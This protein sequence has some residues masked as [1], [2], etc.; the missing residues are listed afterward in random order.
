VFLLF[1]YKQLKFLGTFDC[2]KSWNRVRK[3][4]EM[5]VSVGVLRMKMTWS[6]DC[7]ME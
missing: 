4:V 6:S 3:V 5:A 7:G 1:L 2:W